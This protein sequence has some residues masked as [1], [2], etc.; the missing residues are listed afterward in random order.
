MEIKSKGKSR[1][2]K[3]IKISKGFKHK[4]GYEKK[5]KHWAVFG[6][7]IA[8]GVVIRQH[9]DIPMRFLISLSSCDCCWTVPAEASAHTWDDRLLQT[10]AKLFSLQRGTTYIQWS[11]KV[12]NVVC[13]NGSSTWAAWIPYVWVQTDHVLHD[14]GHLYEGIS[15]SISQIC[16]F[17][18]LFSDLQIVQNTIHFTS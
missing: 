15:W 1:E 8:K 12:R 9:C 7:A 2:S 4:T 11:L 10:D 5:R 3:K 6:R 18:C 16:L 13:F 17:N 14:S